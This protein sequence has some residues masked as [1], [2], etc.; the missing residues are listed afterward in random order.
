MPTVLHVLFLFHK[1]LWYIITH[2][3]GEKKMK[4][5]QLNNLLIAILLFGLWSSSSVPEVVFTALDHSFQWSYDLILKQF[6]IY[7]P[8]R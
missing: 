5:W 6:Y 4:V 8:G 1:I 3:V 2:F 7:F